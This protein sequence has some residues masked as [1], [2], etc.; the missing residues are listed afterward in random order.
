MGKIK[1]LYAENGKLLYSKFFPEVPPIQASEYKDTIMMNEYNR[2]MKQ[3]V[4]EAIP[5]KNPDKAFELIAFGGK[6]ERDTVYEIECAFKIHST[7]ATG[8]YEIEIL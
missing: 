5:V 8:G 7:K 6:V 4:S 1:L 3:A 2:K